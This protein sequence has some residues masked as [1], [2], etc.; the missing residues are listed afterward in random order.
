MG[1]APRPAGEDNMKPVCVD[2]NQNRLAPLAEAQLA[3]CR[4][5]PRPCLVTFLC[6]QLTELS[7][8]PEPAPGA[9]PATPAA[10][11]AA[12]LAAGPPPPAAGAASWAALKRASG[13]GSALVH[14]AY[15][16]HLAESPSPADSRP[17]SPSGEAAP[18][19]PD[20]DL[21]G[22][23]RHGDT[24]LVCGAQHVQLPFLGEDPGSPSGEPPVTGED[25][26]GSDLM[27]CGEGGV[28]PGLEGL[29]GASSGVEGTSGETDEQ[30]SAFPMLDTVSSK[31]VA[32][33]P[34]IETAEVRTEFTANWKS[35]SPTE[36]ESEDASV[37]VSKSPLRCAAAVPE[38]SR[39]G[40]VS[41]ETPPVCRTETPEMAATPKLLSPGL[42]LLA[43]AYT[44]NH[45]DSES[46]SSEIPETADLDISPS[47][48][49]SKCAQLETGE[50]QL[51]SSPGREA[52]GTGLVVNF[53]DLSCELP[54]ELVGAGGGSPSLTP[55]KAVSSPN[56]ASQETPCAPVA[57]PAENE[58]EV[59]RE[60]TPKPTPSEGSSD[61]ERPD[62]V[63]GDE[64]VADEKR[65][66]SVMADKSSPIAHGL[67]NLSS[68]DASRAKA[69]DKVTWEQGGVLKAAV[70][71]M[72]KVS[73]NHSAELREVQK[74]SVVGHSSP[75][76]ATEAEPEGDV[77]PTADP[78]C[79]AE[80]RTE[81]TET[82]C[83]S[84]ESI[85][86]R[87]KRRQRAC[88]AHAVLTPSPSTP[89]RG[90]GRP[91]K[92]PQDGSTV[93][94]S[95]TI[96]EGPVVK[97]C[98]VRLPRL[99]LE[100]MEEL[101]RTHGLQPEATDPNTSE[102]DR[103]PLSC[104]QRCVTRSF[105][106]SEA[107]TDT[108]ARPETNGKSQVD[109][110]TL[111]D[112]K[113][114]TQDDVPVD[115]T[116]LED[117]GKPPSKQMAAKEPSETSPER[118]ES[119]PVSKCDV[120]GNLKS[121]GGDSKHVKAGKSLVLRLCKVGEAVYRNISRTDVAEKELPNSGQCGSSVKQANLGLANGYS[122][123][124]SD[125]KPNQKKSVRKKIEPPSPD[126]P[127][128]KTYEDIG[129]SLPPKSV[130]SKIR[131]E[132]DNDRFQPRPSVS[133]KRRMNSDR[134]ERKRLVSSSDESQHNGLEEGEVRESPPR[135]SKSSSSR[136]SSTIRPERTRR[137]SSPDAIKFHE[138]KE[139]RKNK[140]SSGKHQNDKK[141]ESRD[142]VKEKRSFF[143]HHTRKEKRQDNKERPSARELH[144]E[145]RDKT[146]SS[147]NER[148]K[149]KESRYASSTSGGSKLKDPSTKLA[150]DVLR[151]IRISFSSKK[152][153]KDCDDVD[154]QVKLERRE[155]RLG[156][157]SCR[158]ER[159]RPTSRPSS[160]EEGKLSDSE[161]GSRVESQF[162]KNSTGVSSILKAVC[163][164]TKTIRDFKI[165]KRRN[166]PPSAKPDA[167]GLS[168]SS[169]EPLAADRHLP[170]PTYATF[171]MNS[172]VGDGLPTGTQS[173]R[174]TCAPTLP[175]PQRTDSMFPGYPVLSSQSQQPS[176]AVGNAL[177]IDPSERSA[178]PQ[179]QWLRDLEVNPNQACL[180]DSFLD[181][182][183]S[184]LPTW[185]QL[186]SDVP[187]LDT[188]SRLDQEY[189][190]EIP[191]ANPS[192]PSHRF[193]EHLGH[194]ELP[195]FA[196]GWNPSPPAN[197][198]LQNGCGS[199]K[200]DLFST[201]TF[202]PHTGM[203]PSWHSL[204]P[205]ERVSCL[206]MAHF[207]VAKDRPPQPD[208]SVSQNESA[209]RVGPASAAPSTVSSES[210]VQGKNAS[211]F[212]QQNA[213]V[214]HNL[215]HTASSTA[216]AHQTC[217]TS[218]GP[219]IGKPA[220]CESSMEP[221]SARISYAVASCDIDAIPLHL[222]LND[223]NDESR[224]HSEHSLSF[225]DKISVLSSLPS[226]EKSHF[227]RTSLTS[228]AEA[229][230]LTE[231]GTSSTVPGGGGR[232]T[233][234]ARLDFEPAP[235]SVPAA[236]DSK[237]TGGAPTA[238]AGSQLKQL[239]D[240]SSKDFSSCAPGEKVDCLPWNIIDPS[241]LDSNDNENCRDM[242]LVGED[243]IQV[244]DGDELEVAVAEA[245]ALPPERAPYEFVE[246]ISDDP[247]EN[248]DNNAVEWEVIR[249]LNSDSD[250]YKFVRQRWRN[251]EIPD[252]HRNLTS[253]GY[254]Q[255]LV[256]QN[257]ERLG[258]VKHGRGLK[259]T[260][261]TTSLPRPATK[262]R[263]LA[264]GCTFVLDWL[265]AQG[266]TVLTA[267]RILPRL[268]KRRRQMV[269]E[270]ERLSR[271]LSFNKDLTPAQRKWKVKMMENQ[272][273]Q[274]LEMEFGQRAQR[275]SR[276]LYMN[277]EETETFFKF[278]TNLKNCDGSENASQLSEEQREEVAD[279]ENF[280]E[281]MNSVYGECL[282]EDL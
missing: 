96:S 131:V 138:R 230:A 99:S 194:E 187:G 147:H 159:W 245:A 202:D 49:K 267:G 123:G 10:Q 186:C 40:T 243:E 189:G 78:E 45:D 12:Q 103:N 218:G 136:L 170:L 280:I 39:Q 85:C 119:A 35:T 52:D 47:L 265:L 72:T 81:C 71:D 14:A 150:S 154:R 153:G 94:P 192:P 249:R 3:L 95:R 144:G 206:N 42:R 34:G 271:S 221:S 61:T 279:F 262:R 43:E 151:N 178:N 162:G 145:Q 8:L 114:P 77:R 160:R 59:S 116:S 146:S 237:P 63:K 19:A 268:A 236:G 126:V 235:G 27:A 110:N 276:R 37:M 148:P 115:V 31:T 225:S 83:E 210:L 7:Q 46:V 165:P 30:L 53:P 211:L 156:D 88:S 105:S 70:Q 120:N 172:K 213:E 274:Q 255:R 263:R 219:P 124:H 21:R 209:V 57:A 278:Y 248:A 173:N 157:R 191:G 238:A 196:T 167:S 244:I 164:S 163:A 1:S 142:A 282:E 175:Q 68:S 143:Q 242:V 76:S 220:A 270:Q 193:S 260:L 256:R 28:V 108:A 20:G 125:V 101:Y 51:E 215:D 240:W 250:R 80:T 133:E 17:D 281:S 11:Y 216:S 272:H 134:R 36:Q 109:A 89:H 198:L 184:Q 9:P 48:L 232:P 141:N 41:S 166:K 33:L 64:E 54:A 5:S 203:F 32:E 275:M 6:E 259:R 74:P 197:Q 226:S 106:P 168:S 149:Q 137:E 117:C 257:L 29:A 234:R 67:L 188:R 239:A 69:E 185:S 139:D 171:E 241:A 254:R 177:P 195:P 38:V 182:K 118:K 66:G 277:R 73:E 233:K 246:F 176:K 207:Q 217:P 261:S 227:S 82:V 56:A 50:A 75:R 2:A 190:V 22:T 152:G 258:L 223:K 252:P 212:T 23:V 60:P 44:D 161:K 180:T 4:L 97:P 135:R 107:N 222:S 224:V 140:N 24:A 208:L 231:P 269:A 181:L 128:V 79:P 264:A 183:D 113:G 111:R 87:I 102:C 204:H 205:M 155:G 84:Q 201:E 112:S 15:L 104:G 247:A 91:R 25:R 174:S 98:L 251:T 229:T 13:G 93:A 62:A 179:L 92:Q 253:F 18:S 58:D 127:V 65:G 129:R 214:S 122:A 199:A 130:L 100:D 169:Q 16:R 266:R 132:A 273:V 158:E 26:S 200:R 121:M 228:P 55:P 86:E 90:R